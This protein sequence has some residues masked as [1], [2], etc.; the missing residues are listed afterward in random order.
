MG[1][2]VKAV[3]KIGPAKLGDVLLEHILVI[4]PPVVAKNGLYL[5]ATLVVGAEG[6][7]SAIGGNRPVVGHQEG[8]REVASISIGALRIFRATGIELATEIAQLGDVGGTPG[9]TRR[10]RHTGC[11]RRRANT[12]Q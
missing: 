3:H 12:R 2:F 8:R 6:V 9:M 5:V 11:I 1:A 4:A 7:V 10:R